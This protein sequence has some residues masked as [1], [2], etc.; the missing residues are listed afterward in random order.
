MILV[1]S[2]AMVA[3]VRIIPSFTYNKCFVYPYCKR[4]YID[5]IYELDILGVS[6]KLSSYQVLFH[7]GP[8]LVYCNYMDCGFLH[9]FQ[10]FLRI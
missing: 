10:I 3:I 9:V 2:A 8:N 4:R 6:G 5:L 7:I 1:R